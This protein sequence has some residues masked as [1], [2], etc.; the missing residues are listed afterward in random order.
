MD[1][2]RWQRVEGVLDRVLA[3]SPE[4]WPAL[5]DELCVDDPALRREVEALLARLPRAS[6]FLESP[7]SAAARALIADNPDTTGAR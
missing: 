5:L 3:E 4:R 6:E 2:Q 7:P 1:P